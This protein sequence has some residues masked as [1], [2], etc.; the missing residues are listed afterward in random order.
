MY[1]RTTSLLMLY[2]RNVIPTG[3]LAPLLEH[4]ALSG[5]GYADFHAGVNFRFTEFSEVGSEVRLVASC[6]LWRGYP[7]VAEVGV[8]CR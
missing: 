3:G 5:W 6:L 7:T 4:L 1:I 8:A 2:K